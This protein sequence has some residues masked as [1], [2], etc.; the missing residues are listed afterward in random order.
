MVRIE[1]SFVLSSLLRLAPLC[2]GEMPEGWPMKTKTQ[3]GSAVGLGRRVE[4]AL[5]QALN[6]QPAARFESAQIG[7]L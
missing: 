4:L 6:N 7:L 3:N 5:N 1:L 2:V